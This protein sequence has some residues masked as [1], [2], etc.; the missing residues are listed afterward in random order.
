M[1]KRK[2]APVIASEPLKLNLG[3]GQ[4]RKE[5]FKSVDHH[6]FPGIDITA[7]LTQRWPWGDETVAEIWMN[8]VLEHFTGKQRV[9]IFNEMGRV[10]QKGGT[11]TVITPSWSSSR[12]YGDFTHQW[13]PVSEQAYAYLSRVWRLDKA[14]DTDI[15]FN[16]D[17]Y[18]CDL[19]AT[20]GWSGFHPE[21]VGRSDDTVRWWLTFGKEAA[22]DLLAT[23][24]KP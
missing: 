19:K 14:P 5:G 13:P 10:L 15:K 4:E 3:A 23:I 20:V 18:S 12:A 17:G 22:F 11:A 1:A 16:P 9:H 6:R 2:L 7:D 24:T 8:H 21:L